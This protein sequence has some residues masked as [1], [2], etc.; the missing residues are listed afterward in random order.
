MAWQSLE[1]TVSAEHA[2]IWSE[3]LLECGAGSVSIA[4]AAAGTAGE[5]PLYGEPGMAVP[6]GWNLSVVAALFPPDADVAACLADCA[7]QTGSAGLPAHQ[8]REVA[9][10]DWVR[11]TQEQFAPIAIS[12]RLWIVPSWHVCPD[13]S[14][15]AIVLDAGL[16][17][18]LGY[19]GN[20]CA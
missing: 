3:A 6:P 18:R 4:D 13:P 10:Q 5:Q 12:R 15:I 1:L 17:L 14:A 9:D 20:S 19:I 11:L 16:R 7:A 2:E 8:L